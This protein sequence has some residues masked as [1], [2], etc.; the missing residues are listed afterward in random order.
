MNKTGAVGRDGMT[1]FGRALLEMNID[2]ICDN[3]SQAK[4]RL[5]GAHLTLQDPLFKEHIRKKAL[6]PFP[7]TPALM[8]LF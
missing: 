7:A 2:I 5:E 1:R 4:G 6:S 8:L 3:A